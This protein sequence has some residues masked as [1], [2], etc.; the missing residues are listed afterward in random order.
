MPNA[1]VTVTNLDNNL[2]KASTTD[3][4]G[5][6]RVPL[7]PP[8]RYKITAAS[9]GFSTATTNVG[10]A[11]GEVTPVTMKLAVGQAATTVEVTSGSGEVLH[12]DDAQ[13]STNF[14]LEQMQTLPNPGNDLTFVAQ[15]TPGAVMNTQS[16]YGNFSVNGLPG[17]SNTF[18]VNGGY[19][20]DPY[21]NLNNSGATNLLLGNNDVDNGDR[22]HQ[23][24]RRCIWRTGWRAGKRDFAGRRQPVAWQSALLV[25][26]PRSMNANNFFNKQAGVAAE[27]RQR[28]PV[29][30][31][32]WR[33]IEEG[34][35]LRVHRHG[36]RARHHSREPEVIRTEP[37]VPGGRSG[38]CRS[39]RPNSRALR[40]SCGQR[41]CSR[42]P[43]LPDDFQLLQRCQELR[44]RAASILPIPGPGSGNGQTTNFGREWLVNDRVDF[45]L[46]QNDHLFIHS[47]VDKGVQPTQTSFL[48]SD[49]Q[50]GEPAAFL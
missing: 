4:S 28:Q 47:K 43:G 11:A 29:G 36:R 13:I 42:S 20:G 49:F 24:L 8:G 35:G 50:C 18:T 16:G 33:S 45:N 14:N 3:P 10:V 38:R 12:T 19:E 5:N 9:S 7:L 21:L 32:D 17:T 26:R 40:Q 31:G 15:T 2:Q 1:Q 22:D 6:F 27:L 30:C 44:R 25:E 46:G 39:G 23:Q 48:D 34:Q 37:G 41:K